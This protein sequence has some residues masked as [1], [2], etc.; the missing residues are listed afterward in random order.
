MCFEIGMLLINLVDYIIYI[1][2]YIS[3]CFNKTT[4]I[5]A[6]LSFFLM[7]FFSNIFMSFDSVVHFLCISHNI[8]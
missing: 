7:L 8:L 1:Y 5:C 3:I 4:S 2:T 6:L